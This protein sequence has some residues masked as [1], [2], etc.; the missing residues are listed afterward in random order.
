MFLPK[1]EVGPDAPAL[2]GG[3][4]IDIVGRQEVPQGIGL[5][6]IEAQRFSLLFGGN[7]RV[8]VRPGH[9]NISR[10][11]QTFVQLVDESDI[12]VEGFVLEVLLL[13]GVV[14]HFVVGPQGWGYAGFPDTLP[15][16]CPS[17]S[18]IPC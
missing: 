8:Q 18:P 15:R 3:D 2:I 13:G 4:V 6:I 11:R 12:S 17:R 16:A 1:D 9:K 14:P 7:R 10:R 5:A